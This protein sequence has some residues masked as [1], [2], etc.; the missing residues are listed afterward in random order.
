[1]FVYTDSGYVGDVE[2]RKSTSG[3]VFLL[4]SGLVSW[5]S[6]KQPIVTLSTTEVEFV[7]VAVCACQV[8]WVKKILKELG[9]SDGGCVCVRCDNNSTIKLS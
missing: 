9:H 1:M 6:K 3:Y 2:D 4:S 8:I 7:A 5:S